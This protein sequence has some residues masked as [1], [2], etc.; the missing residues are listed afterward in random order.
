MEPYD[1]N[2]QIE[3]FLNKLSEF[4]LPSY[5]KFPDLDLYM[6]QVI[7][8]L[9][10]EMSTLANDNSPLI[11]SSMINNYVK[12]GVITPPV[13]KKYNREHLS[14]IF[15]IC[16]LKPVL[17]INDIGEMLKMTKEFPDEYN[18]KKFCALQRE[19]IHDVIREIGV[20]FPT[21]KNDLLFLSFKLAV[22]AEVKKRVAEFILHL[23]ILK[24]DQERSEKK[25]NAKKVETVKQPK[26]EVSN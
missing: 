23:V 18:Y 10:R 17:S 1:I 12:N 5:E 6:D 2:T 24:E 16:A 3:S 13:S 8:Y 21:K 25:K 22:E 20:D 14:D 19:A 4:T 9:E 26:S 11:T 15:V 7:T